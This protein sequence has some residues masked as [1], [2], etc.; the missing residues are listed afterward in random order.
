MNSLLRRHPPFKE[1]A[2]LVRV[3]S[4]RGDAD[5]GALAV[6]D[7]D[8]LLALPVSGFGT[9]EELQAT[10]TTHNLFRVL[11]VEPFVGSTFPASFDRTRSFGLVISHGLWVRKFGED[12]NIVG[13]S[14]T[15]DG[16][17][18]CTIYGVM[19]PAFNF[20]SSRQL[21]PYVLLLFGAVALVLTMACANVA[22]LLSRV[23]VRWPCARRSERAD[24]ASSA[25]SRARAYA[26]VTVRFMATS[27]N[28]A[29]HQPVVQREQTRQDDAGR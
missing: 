23:I 25:R 5:G 9:P 6:P 3:T 16:A 28:A 18:G 10:V 17:S 4:V 27:H 13:R 11:G 20:P 22:N 26:W 19:P 24:G 14:I 12:P 7:L 1:P 29:W 2:R 8:D 21:W 15:L